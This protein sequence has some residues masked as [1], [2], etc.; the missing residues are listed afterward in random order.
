MAQPWNDNSSFDEGNATFAMA[1]A[2]YQHFQRRLEVEQL[3]NEPKHG[4]TSSCQQRVN[5]DMEDS[6]V[7]C[8]H[9]YFS[10]PPLS[11]PSFSQ[12]RFLMR[13]ELFDIIM[14]GVVNF[15]NYFPQ[16]LSANK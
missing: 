1:R 2:M 5:R 6:H 9:N 4:G 13:C 10:N 7:R 16:R 14:E 8:M 15:D 3:Q 11:P 12:A